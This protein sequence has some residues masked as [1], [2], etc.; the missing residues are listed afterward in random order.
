MTAAALFNDTRKISSREIKYSEFH[1]HDSEYEYLVGVHFQKYFLNHSI[2]VT[3]NY[4]D[5]Y[6]LPFGWPD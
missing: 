2:I 3:S 5:A 1:H 6:D 4:L